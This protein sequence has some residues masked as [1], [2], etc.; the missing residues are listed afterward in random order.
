[1]QKFINYLEVY[2][3]YIITSFFI[4]I[5]ALSGSL[6]YYINQPVVTEVIK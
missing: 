1:M 2:Y 5:I 6:F 4:I 3:L